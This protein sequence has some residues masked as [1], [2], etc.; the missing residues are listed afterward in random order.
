MQFRNYLLIA[1]IDL[2]LVHSGAIIIISA[3]YL[4]GNTAKWVVYQTASG[5]TPAYSQDYYTAVKEN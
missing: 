3:E 2:H 5:H 1:G 4:Q